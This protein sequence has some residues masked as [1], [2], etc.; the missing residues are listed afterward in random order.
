MA[1]HQKNVTLL[2]LLL[3]DLKYKNIFFDLDGTL[4]DSAA[5]ITNSVMYALNRRGIEVPDRQSLYRFIGPP[6]VDSFIKYYGFTRE[7]AME[8]VA[9]YR[10]YFSTKGIFENELMDG[11]VE[12]LT[13]LKAHGCH[14]YVCTA[15]P[16]KFTDIILR[17]FKIDGFFDAVFTASMD[18]KLCEKEDILRIGLASIEDK[19]SSVMVG[20]RYNDIEGAKSNGIDSIGV[21][22]GFGGEKEL[23]EAG[24][25]TIVKD[26]HEV[27]ELIINQ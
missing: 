13:A 8:S 2:L 12:M 24:A 20:D 22:C 6:L 27:A 7:E 1:F 4:T 18:G 5:G 26:L 25:T 15:K 21:L 10:E 16:D 3:N 23:S 9:V 14:L 11:C 17:H 19:S